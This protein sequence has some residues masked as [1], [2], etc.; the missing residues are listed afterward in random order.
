[1][2]KWPLGLLLITTDGAELAAHPPENVVLLLI[3]IRLSKAEFSNKLTAP[4]NVM[5]APS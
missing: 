4:K 2:T 3:V 5:F 1:M